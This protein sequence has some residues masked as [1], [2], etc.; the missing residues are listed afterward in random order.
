VLA[1]AAITLGSTRSDS[2]NTAIAQRNPRSAEVKRTGRC[3]L[4][5]NAL[6]DAV[7][8]RRKYSSSA[9]R[10]TSGVERPKRENGD[11]ISPQQAFISDDMDII[12]I[13]ELTVSASELSVSDDMDIIS[14]DE[15]TVSASE[16]SISDDMDIISAAELSISDDMDIISVNE[17]TVS[18]AEP[19][20]SDDMD[21]IGPNE[22]A[23]SSN[24]A[25]I[26]TV[27]AASDLL[28]LVCHHPSW[29]DRPAQALP[30]PLASNGRV[31]RTRVAGCQSI[32][33][34]A[35]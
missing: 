15:L 12:S 29:S 5:I 17:L 8:A 3:E 2:E 16:P 34:R 23:I 33:H 28:R 19:S 27:R 14:I 7:S 26:S 20:V 24:E 25:A 18:A 4:R 21:I 35:R 13:D 22:A 10:V 6:K 9:Y 32:T 31:G 1:A 11:V 30:E